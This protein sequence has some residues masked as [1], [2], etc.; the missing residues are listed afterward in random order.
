MLSLPPQEIPT[1]EGD[2]LHFRSFI[3]SF[4]QGVEQKAEEIDCLYYLEHFTRG[5]PRELVRSCQHMVPERGYM[6]ARKLLQEQFENPSNTAYMERALAWQTIKSENVELLQARSL[7]L[8]G[9]CNVMEKLTYVHKL[10]MPVNMGIIMSKLRF[11][12]RE[13]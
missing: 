6:V 11:K 5:Q 2:L 7:F 3:K 8:R 10:D 13:Q 9:C 4:D 1:F 12:M